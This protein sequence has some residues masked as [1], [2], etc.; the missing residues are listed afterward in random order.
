MDTLLAHAT[1]FAFLPEGASFGDKEVH[2]FTIT[3]TRRSA[4]KW[5]VLRMNDCWNKESQS[6][7]YEPSERSD[8]FLRECRFPLE[9]AVQI[10]RGLPD[11]LTING[12]SWLDFKEIHARQEANR[13]AASAHVGA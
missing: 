3:V 1:E 13:K 8:T 6:W 11:G 7:E 10:A 5:A 2:Y 4:D 12:K 9:E